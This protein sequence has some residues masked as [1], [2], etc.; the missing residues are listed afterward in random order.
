MLQRRK[1]GRKR[2]DHFVDTDRDKRT[3]IQRSLQPLGPKA[4]LFA[5]DR[6]DH[7]ALEHD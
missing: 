4:L 3:F 5:W 1:M 6:S 7:L 2:N